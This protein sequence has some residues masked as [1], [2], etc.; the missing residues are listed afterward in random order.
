M[1]LFN[2]CLWRRYTWYHANRVAMSR[3]NRMLVSENWC[4]TLGGA[5]IW[6]LP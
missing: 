3:P 6:V 2:R 4:R 1:S 5:S